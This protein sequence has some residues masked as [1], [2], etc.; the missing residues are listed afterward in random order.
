VEEALLGAYMGQQ[1]DLGISGLMVEFMSRVRMAIQQTY[2]D[3]GLDMNASIVIKNALTN[4][5]RISYGV[6]GV[7]TGYDP[8]IGAAPP[9]APPQ[10]KKEDKKAKK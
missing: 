2:R 10:G 6:K 4:L 3:R 9:M 7:E 8:E 5:H 1:G